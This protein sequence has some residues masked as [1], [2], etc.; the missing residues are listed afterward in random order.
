MN[1][2]DISDQIRELEAQLSEAPEDENLLSQLADALV[3]RM[4]DGLYEEGKE[5]ETRTADKDRLETVLQCLSPDK[6][7]YSRAYLA[8]TN[9]EDEEAA[10]WIGKWTVAFS[11]KEP[12]F[13][14]ETCFDNLVAPFSQASPS[15]WKSAAEGF[16]RNW[17]DAAVVFYLK[18]LCEEEEQ[19]SEK[20]LT[21]FKKAFEQ[22]PSFWRA[23]LGIAGVYFDTRDWDT[24]IDYLDLCLQNAIAQEVSLVYSLK[25]FCLHQLERYSDEEI[26]YQ[27]CLKLDPESPEAWTRFGCCLYLQNKF[28][29]ALDAFYKAIAYSTNSRPLLWYKIKTLEKLGRSIDADAERDRIAPELS[30]PPR[31]FLLTWN[32]QKTPWDTLSDEISEARR[33]GF[34][35]ND[36]SCGNTKNIHSGDRFYLLCQGKGPTGIVGTGKI[37]SDVWEQ[38]H[39]D[40]EGAQAGKKAYYVDVEWETLLDPR[41]APPLDRKLLMAEFPQ[42]NWNTQRSGI[43]IKEGVPE[44]LEA[45]WA[46]HIRALGQEVM[47]CKVVEEER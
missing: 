8:Y 39:W 35:V 1:S 18:G 29:G 21:S 31:T 30:M 40:V 46:E 14:S 22:D 24:T 45:T 10:Q 15:F 28:D 7:L 41:T 43:R 6:G 11:G 44:R 12:P 27:S 5:Q 38:P 2:I 33:M 16:E 34:Y 9:Y 32:P 25:A 42:V 13:D 20:A 4:I 17:S 26:A 19:E 3:D 36:W 23:N 47:Y 37:I